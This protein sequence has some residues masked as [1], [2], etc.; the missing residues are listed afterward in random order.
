M[1]DKTD[2]LQDVY[3]CSGIIDD[4][5]TISWRL[6]DGSVLEDDEYLKLVDGL[7]ELYQIKFEKLLETV[8]SIFED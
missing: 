1:S 3:G 8:N 6:Q 2:I 7:S 4:L 5:Q